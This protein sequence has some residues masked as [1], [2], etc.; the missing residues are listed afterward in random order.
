VSRPREL[1]AVLTSSRTWRRYAYLVIGA[2]LVAPY[3]TLAGFV[4]PAL[5]GGLGVDAAWAVAIVVCCVA[6]P[7]ATGMLAAVRGLE[8]TPAR[9]S[10]RISSWARS[11]AVS[12]S[13]CRRPWSR[14]SRPRS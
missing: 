9:G 6:L 11:S 4:A 1:L 7:I 13:S 14:R 12:P 8:I 2:A 5:E 3:P 10:P